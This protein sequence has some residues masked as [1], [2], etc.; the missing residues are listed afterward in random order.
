[1]VPIVEVFSLPK[2]IV[3]H[4]VTLATIPHFSH[5]RSQIRINADSSSAVFAR[6]TT[7]SAKP[8]AASRISAPSRE[9]IAPRPLD[10]SSANSELMKMIN[11]I[12]DKGSPCATPRSTLKYLELTPSIDTHDFVPV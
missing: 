9:K 2:T 10:S 5:Q 11:R 4:L 6:T 8:S 12:R 7:S 3:A 1:M